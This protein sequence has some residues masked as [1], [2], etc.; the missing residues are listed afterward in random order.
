MDFG[1]RK[2]AATAVGM[3]DG[4][5]YLGT[6]VQSLSLGYITTQNWAWWPPFLIPFAVIGFVL[7]LRIW[8]ARAGKGGH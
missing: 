2:A 8:N 5:V 6:A 3:I 4:F 1:G 7:C